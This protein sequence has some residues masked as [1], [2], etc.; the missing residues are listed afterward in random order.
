MF[1]YRLAW[2]TRSISGRPEGVAETGEDDPVPT[3]GDR[4]RRHHTERAVDGQRV[5]L[6]VE[7]RHTQPHAELRLEPEPPQRGAKRVGITL[8]DEFAVPPIMQR[9]IGMLIEQRV[10]PATRQEAQRQQMAPRPPRAQS[11]NGR[12]SGRT[13]IRNRAT[14]TAESRA[15]HARRAGIRQSCRGPPVPPAVRRS[16]TATARR[17]RKSSPVRGRRGP[18]PASRD[19]PRT[20]AAMRKTAQRCSRAGSSRRR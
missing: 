5:A 13:R 17:W 14:A 1:T 19:A 10:Q 4:Q 3:V 12:R 11:C 9:R 16:C 15:A 7:R 8:A 6:E 2:P 18:R 20:E